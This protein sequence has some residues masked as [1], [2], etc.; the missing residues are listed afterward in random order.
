MN[1]F[2]L[3]LIEH[4][5]QKRYKIIYDNYSPQQSLFLKLIYIANVCLSLRFN[6]EKKKR[7]INQRSG[8]DFT[9]EKTMSSVSLLC[10][11]LV[12][13]HPKFTREEPLV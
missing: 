11:I 12:V 5:A 10:G 3:T 6:I 2:I 7:S 13:W 9:G 1:R 4:Q 8:L